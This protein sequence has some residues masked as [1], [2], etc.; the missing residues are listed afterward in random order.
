MKVH[1]FGGA[2]VK[3]ANGL[4]SVAKIMQSLGNESCCFVLSAMGKTTNALESVAEAHYKQTGDAAE[5][6]AQSKA[7]HEDVLAELFP[8]GHE[9]FNTINDLFVEVDWAL[10]DAPRDD[11]GFEYD[12]IVAVGEL[13]STSILVAY[14]KDLGEEIEWL[15]ARD[16][17]KT[18][19][20]YRNARVDWE[21]TEQAI[22]SKVKKGKKYL[23][24]GF[25]GCTTENFTTTLGREGSDYTAAILA[26]VL[27]ADEV[28]VWKD[29][30]GMLN[31]DPRFFTDTQKL[32]LIHI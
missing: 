12:Q 14:L 29:V 5:I 10:E 28:N 13:L 4:R 3:D 19:N 7:F 24:Q 6:L 11:F 17:V 25:I 21:L 20:S 15:D 2:S 26:Y 18:D 22:K 31:A 27:D 9:V 8:A 1:K 16:L 32:S 23:T 30:P